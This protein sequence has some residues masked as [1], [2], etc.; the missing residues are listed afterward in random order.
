MLNYYVTDHYETKVIGYLSTSSAFFS[1]PS[2]GG[3][4]SGSTYYNG[5]TA[6]DTYHSDYPDALYCQVQY[7]VVGKVIRSSDSVVVATSTTD[8][9]V[10]YV[11]TF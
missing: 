5:W 9:D 1:S 8:T 4:T 11:R 3:S 2:T 7:R 10:K 6:A